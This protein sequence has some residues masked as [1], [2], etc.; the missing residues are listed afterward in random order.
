[1]KNTEK[2]LDLSVSERKKSCFTTELFWRGT[3]IQLR[4]LK[5]QKDNLNCNSIDGYV[6]RKNSSR[7]KHGPSERQF[8][9]NTCSWTSTTS[10]ATP[11][12]RRSRTRMSATARQVYGRN[13]A[14]LHTNSSEQTKASK[15]ESTHRRKWR[16]WPR[17]WSENRMETVPR[18]A[19]KLAAYFV[20]VVFIMAEFL[21]AKLEFMVVAFFKI[22]RST[23]SDFFWQ[24]MQFRMVG[25]RIAGT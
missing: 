20:F 2:S 24:S 14:A 11:R 4:K 21:M 17:G 12:I 9:F 16:L 13:Q 23:V 1:M 18:A 10:T 6:I 7:G 8:V 5:F 19:V 3:T 15:S 25:F 22:W